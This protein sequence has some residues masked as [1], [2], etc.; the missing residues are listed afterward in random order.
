MVI[1]LNFLLGGEYAPF[2][3]LLPFYLNF[4]EICKGPPLDIFNIFLAVS[5][6]LFPPTD[7]IK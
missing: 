3:Y 4:W 2:G 6:Y 5:S 1:A 7:F